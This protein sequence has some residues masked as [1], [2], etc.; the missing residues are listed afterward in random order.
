MGE[1]FVSLEIDFPAYISQR[2]SCIHTPLM[3]M[4]NKVNEMCL[5]EMIQDVLLHQ[6]IDIS[7]AHKDRGIFVGAF[8]CDIIFDL[9]VQEQIA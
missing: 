1:P 7:V 5:I 3:P 6:R 4:K 8:R 2:F 9:V